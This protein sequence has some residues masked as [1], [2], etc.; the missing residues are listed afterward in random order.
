[1]FSSFEYTLTRDDKDVDVLVEYQA[2]RAFGDVDIDLISVTLDG[3]EIDTTE[4]ED[5]KL[6]E[7]CFDRVDEDFIAE[8]DAYGDYRY[9]MSRDED[10]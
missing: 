7:A 10:R 9:E 2:S 3:V 6:I 5:R 1:M 8:E 4:E